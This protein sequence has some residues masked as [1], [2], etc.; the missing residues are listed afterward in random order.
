MTGDRISL[1]CAPDPFPALAKATPRERGFLDAFLWGP[2]K[3]PVLVRK[4]GLHPE[5]TLPDGTTTG[6]EPHVLVQIGGGLIHG[7]PYYAD[8]TVS[9]EGRSVNG[10]RRSLL[11]IRGSGPFGQSSTA[12]PEP[13]I[14]AA[15]PYLLI[16]AEKM[17][18]IDAI[19]AEASA[20][21]AVLQRYPR[22]FKTHAEYEAACAELGVKCYPDDRCSTWGEFLFP[23]YL[24]EQIIQA[25][26]SQRR[27][28][29]LED[30]RRAAEAARLDGLRRN[31]PP[32]MDG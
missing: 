18:R 13:L 7:V 15:M 25:V 11:I 32:Q 16:A 26:L 19:Y 29:Q 10:W 4:T 3:V 27:A 31:P 17:W 8:F 20:K 22:Q 6:K 2:D 14:E 24:P 28:Y 9:A 1:P 30:E 23:Q 5:A 21:L 12:D